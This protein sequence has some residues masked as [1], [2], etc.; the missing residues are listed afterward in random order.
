MSRRRKRCPTGRGETLRLLR[1]KKWIVLAAFAVGAAVGAGVAIAT[2]TN[3]IPTVDTNT[4]REKIVHSEFVPSAD[5]PEFS[6]G[7]HKHPGPV[8]VQVQDGSLKIT[9]NTCNPTVVGAGETFVEGDA[10]LRQ[11][12]QAAQAMSHA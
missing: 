8:I 12:Q 1:S 10:G 11:W 4:V 7:W 3:P 2:V 9:Q 6:S 5:Q